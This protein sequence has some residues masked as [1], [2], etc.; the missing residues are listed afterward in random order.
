ML[1]V[2][3]SQIIPGVLIVRVDGSQI[4]LNTEDM[5]NKILIL[6]DNEYKDTKLF[7]LDFEATAFIDHS[8]LKC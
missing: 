3:G 5:K 7:I 2:D 1:N 8:A 6:V 4:F